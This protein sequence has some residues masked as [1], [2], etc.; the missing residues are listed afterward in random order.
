[1]VA[2][3]CRLVTTDPNLQDIPSRT[4]VGRQI[5]RTFVPGRPG[6]VLLSADYDQIELRV[7]A[8]ITGDP[9][10]LDAFRRGEDIH[11]VTAAEVFGVAPDGVTPEMRRQAKVFN[12]GIAYGISD[13]GLASQLGIGRAEAQRF[14]DTYFA[15]YP[16]VQDYTRTTVELARDRKSARLNSSH[17]K[18]S[19]A[20]F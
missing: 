14:M 18:I 6:H 19:Y 13:F 10:L 15:R 16:R 20:V 1:T 5:R 8:H 17:V 2:S 7:L 3:T 12:Y 11:T 9:G 4:D